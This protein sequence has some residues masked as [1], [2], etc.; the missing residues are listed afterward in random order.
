M[1]RTIEMTK[2]ELKRKMVVKQ[3]IDKRFIKKEEAQR[4]VVSD[5]FSGSYRGFGDSVIEG[6]YRNSEREVREK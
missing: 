2:D 6:W 3:A 5:D 1:A 4:I